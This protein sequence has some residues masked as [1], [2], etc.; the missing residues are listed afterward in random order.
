MTVDLESLC[1][2][3]AR[4][5]EALQA[6]GKASGFSLAAVELI[7]LSRAPCVIAE[8]AG[9]LDDPRLT[10]WVGAAAARLGLE[11]EPVEATYPDVET[12]VCGCAPALLG[13][14]GASGTGF[15]ALLPGKPQR[16]G[17][18]APDLTRHEVPV[19]TVRAALCGMLEAG[20]ANEVDDTLQSVA[21]EGG[22]RERAR[23]ALL[24]EL[25]SERR[26]G[27]AGSFVRP[28]G[29]P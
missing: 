9:D 12:M 14:A 4:L 17:I 24:R 6:L 11:A 20:A 23:R 8:R 1:W 16:L 10:P 22:R 3:V 18:L 21:L 29:R 28:G 19:E 26:I 13:I 7:E 15:L 2:P 5:G 27:G 25:L